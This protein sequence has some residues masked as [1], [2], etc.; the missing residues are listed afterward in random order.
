MYVMI[1]IHP[2]ALTCKLSSVIHD[3][4]L[5]ISEPQLHLLGF[6]TCKCSLNFIDGF[7]KDFRAK[8]FMAEKVSVR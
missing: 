7:L 6:I 3:L 2:Q 4:F 8:S 5:G 1:S